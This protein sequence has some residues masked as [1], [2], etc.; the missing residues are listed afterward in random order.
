MITLELHSHL[1]KWTYHCLNDRTTSV[2]IGECHS[3]SQ[4]LG[5]GLPQGAVLS[6]TLN[7]MLSDLPRSPQVKVVSYADDITLAVISGSVATAQNVIQ[8]YLHTLSEWLK[9]WQFTINH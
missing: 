8:C 9:K 4:N 5:R 3:L 7:I 6:T 2:Q 1:I